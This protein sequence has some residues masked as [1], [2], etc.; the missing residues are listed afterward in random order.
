[1]KAHKK[2][3]EAKA[4]GGSYDVQLQNYKDAAA[5]FTAACLHQRHLAAT[6]QSVDADTTHR[7]HSKVDKESHAA[8]AVNYHMVKQ[9]Y[10][11]QGKNLTKMI[12]KY[13]SYFVTEFSDDEDPDEDQSEEGVADSQETILYYDGV[14]DSQQVFREDP[15]ALLEM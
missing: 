3:K 13:Q 10:V 7:H 5:S 14:T 11:N 9:K 6:R 1:M 8:G 12:S 2:W 15:I 4:A